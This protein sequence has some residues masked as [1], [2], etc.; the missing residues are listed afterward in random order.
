MTFQELLASVR[1]YSCVTGDT[2]RLKPGGVFVWGGGPASE[3]SRFLEQGLARGAAV[4]VTAQTPER[5]IDQPVVR[6]ADFREALADLAGAFY[7]HP[8]RKLRLVGVTGTCGKTTTTYLLES[9]F[10]RAGSG[11]GVI[12]TVSFRYPGFEESATHTTPAADELQEL[13]SRM[14]QAGCDT[15]VMEVSSH[16]VKHRRVRGM[17]FD[18]MVF[19]NLSHDHLDFHPDMEDYFST[20]A[21]LF[22]G[23]A[24]NARSVGKD[25]GFVVNGRDPYG[26]RLIDMIRGAGTPPSRLREF[27]PAEGLSYTRD[28]IS[29]T[30]D[31]VAIRS[32]LVGSFNGE[33]ICGAVTLARL[34]GVPTEAIES[35]IASMRRVPGRLEAVA[36][37]SGASVFVDYAHK[38]AALETL[39]DTLSALKGR[40]RLV[41]VF[42]CGGDR[43]RGKRPVMCEIACRFSDQVWVTS[44]NPRT[45]DPQR[46]IDEIV[47]G[48]RAGVDLRTD[49]DRVSAIRG[50]V[51][52]LE[53]GDICVIAGRGHEA[54][55][56]IP[57]PA[58]SGTIKVPLDDRV[59]ASA[60]LQEHAASGQRQ[61]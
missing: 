48:R 9:I 40:S 29:G 19:T 31:G 50:A 17:V 58:G 13:L 41:T 30:V 33:N 25:P 5:E 2:R 49:V 47:A 35:G 22:L 4:V 10:A 38:P 59:I 46:I 28:G 15:V 14:C 24:A 27:A 1:S 54:Y 7:D 45:E 61:G 56:V 39:L 34:F 12:G 55:T 36:G 57:D 3:Q 52:S 20:K 32:S 43:D 51:Q 11:V 8:S 18:G 42:G 37:S 60:A 16:G 26:R 53:Q 21:E 6:V 23:F 44:D